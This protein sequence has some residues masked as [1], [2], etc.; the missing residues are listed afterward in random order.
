LLKERHERLTPREKGIL[1]WVSLGYTSKEIAKAVGISNRT[2]ELHR[3]HMMK[4]LEVE[5]LAE[6]VSIALEMDADMHA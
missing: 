2:I 4:K 6:L 5:S 1:K 3:A